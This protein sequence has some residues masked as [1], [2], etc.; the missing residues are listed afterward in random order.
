MPSSISTLRVRYAETD[1]MGVVYYANYLVWFEVARTD[2]LRTL[3]W[4]YREME[5]T[6]VS[7]PVIETHC[8]Y[9]RPARYDDEIEIR[10]E[11][12]M[13]SPV[14]I[15]FRY[16]VVS[17]GEPDVVGVGPHG[18]RGGERRRAAVPAPAAHPGGV[19]MKALVDRC[20]RIHRIPS[21]RDAA[22]RGR[23]V[24]GVDCFTD[25]YPRSIKEANLAE[26]AAREGFRFVEDRIQ[27]ADLPA[28][29]D[30]VTHVFHLAAQAGVRKSWGQG[31]PDLYREQHRRHASAAGGVRRSAADPLR[32]R[33]ELLGL[34]R[35]VGGPMREDALPRPMSPYGVTKLSAEQLGYLYHVNH[36]VPAVAMRYFTVYGP[37]QR[38][39]MAFH[40]FITAA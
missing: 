7:L 36:G 14:R 35:H 18:A 24:V 1:K 30:G 40:R 22:R 15:E 16:D 11:G 9:H 33:V 25:Y 23:T 31:F 12:R 2:L 26:N 20:C 8:E 38:P 3:G 37:R 32:P 28:L 39:D 13:L 19:R 21:G 4:S 29:L 17:T 27:D 5:H 10:T 6:G 34:R